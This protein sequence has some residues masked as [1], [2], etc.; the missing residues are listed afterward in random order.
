MS[1]SD[2][3][4]LSKDKKDQ[5]TDLVQKKHNLHFKVMLVMFSL[6][7]TKWAYMLSGILRI[8]IRVKGKS[9]II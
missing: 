8:E 6:N 9:K 7:L 1:E 2:K 4:E 3:E 5:T